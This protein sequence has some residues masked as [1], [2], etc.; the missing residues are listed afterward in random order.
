MCTDLNSCRF[1]PTQQLKKKSKSVNFTGTST[2]NN[3]QCK[4]KK[5]C[6]TSFNPKALMGSNAEVR[7]RA[8]SSCRLYIPRKQSGTKA[9]NSCKW[10][11]KPKSV[12]GR[13]KS[14]LRGEVFGEGWSWGAGSGGRFVF[15]C[16]GKRT[17]NGSPTGWISL[18]SLVKQLRFFAFHSLSYLA[19]FFLCWGVA[20][21]K[22]STRKSQRKKYMDCRVAVPTKPQ[23]ILCVLLHISN[24]FSHWVVHEQLSKVKKK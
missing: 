7:G 23:S 13:P 3:N 8:S 24:A 22:G 2:K 11:G 4:R 6:A 20:T 18:H 19:F 10:V 9:L 14:K 15:F 17:L 1:H 12:V 16:G 5:E 21:C